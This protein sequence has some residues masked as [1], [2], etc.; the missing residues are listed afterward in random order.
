MIKLKIDNFGPIKHA[1]LDF[2]KVNILIGQQG[3][4]KSCVLKIA[5]FCMWLE[6]VCNSGRI[7]S[8]NGYIIKRFLE[9]FKLEEFVVVAESNYSTISYSGNRLNI[10]FNFKKNEDNW[11]KIDNNGKPSTLKRVAY[12]PA[13]RC[14]VS[15]IP[16]LLDIRLHDT[17]TLQYLVDWELAHKYYTEKNRLN[18]LDLNA[19]FYNDDKSKIDYLLIN[20]NG[21][22]KL[23]QLSNAASGFQSIVPICVLTNYYLNND[24]TTS[25]REKLSDERKN[26]LTNQHDCALFIEEPEANIFPETQYRLI[27]WLVS[28]MNNGFDNSLFIATHSPYTLSVFNNLIQA[29]TS[30][31]DTNIADIQNIMQMKQF[32]NFDDISV[33]EVTDGT[34]NDIKN[35]EMRLI[36]ANSID[37]VSDIINEQFSKLLEYE[38][39]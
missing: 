6:K 15:A 12:I 32:V 28:A 29:A 16:N 39:I 5:A 20:N 17:C 23:I 35:Y 11:V 37:S 14:L 24:D 30:A 7:I 26:Q 13:E 9:Y 31:N 3:A 33:Y 22:P 19:E 36:D 10:S 21:S 4:G 8:Q 38:G 27:K 25:V 18:I 1:E 2:K 34:V